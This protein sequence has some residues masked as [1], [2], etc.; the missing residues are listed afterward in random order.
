VFSIRS[1]PYNS[2]SENTEQVMRVELENPD[3]KLK[4]N[5]QVYKGTEN[6]DDDR[7]NEYDSEDEANINEVTSNL[8]PSRLSLGKRVCESIYLTLH[9]SHSSIYLGATVKISELTIS[10]NAPEIAP[11]FL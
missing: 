2:Y 5:S 11:L 8:V 6:D 7:Y 3:N 4:A 10:I 1:L 9:L